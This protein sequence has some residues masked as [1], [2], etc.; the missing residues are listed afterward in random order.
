[1]SGKIGDNTGRASGLTKAASSAP[2]SAAGDPALDRDE[3]VGTRYINTTSGELFICTDATA[4][5]NV[6]KGQLGSTVEPAKWYGNRGVIC[7]GY[8]S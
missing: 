6:W 7:G 8:S 5:E 2:T 3:S 1:M 4:G